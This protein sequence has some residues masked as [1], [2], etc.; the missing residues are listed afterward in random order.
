MANNEH[1]IVNKQPKKIQI[2]ESGTQ[3]AELAPVLEAKLPTPTNK[4][5]IAIDNKKKE[6]FPLG[7]N[8]LNLM[9][10]N[11][12]LLSNEQEFLLAKRSHEG[13]LAEAAVRSLMAKETPIVRILIDEGKEAQNQLV[14]H[15]LRL[16][17]SIAKNYVGQGLE[18][19]DLIQEGNIGLQRAAERF[20][21]HLGFKFSTYA[22]GWIKQAVQRALADQARAIRLPAY[23]SEL[24]SK[25]RKAEIQL[26]QDLKREPTTQELAEFL[27]VK[28]ERLKEILQMNQNL[29]SL[30]TPI[31]EDG[32]D[33]LGSFITD[34]SSEPVDEVMEYLR[35]KEINK[36]LDTLKPRERKILELRYGLNGNIPHTLE[37]IARDFRVTRERIRQ[38][39][40]V[41]LKK[42][43]AFPK[44]KEV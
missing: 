32:N 8:T 21:P 9:I 10:G 5:P 42:L 4:Q 35:D 22:T 25:L 33:E 18:L 44:L 26:I 14:E 28:Q 24:L 20:N 7:N 29:V 16:V 3:Q 31:G 13:Y 39:E 19:L 12:P 27:G 11:K 6:T 37:E 34:P 40:I 1:L 15:N 36:A 17:V 23:A 38:I 30:Q 2:E 43:K 41:T